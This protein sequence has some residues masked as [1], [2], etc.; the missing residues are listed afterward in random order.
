M[1]RGGGLLRI[2]QILRTVVVDAPENGVGVWLFG[3]WDCDRAKTGLRH[4]IAVAPPCHV[5]YAAAAYCPAT[6]PVLRS[7]AFTYFFFGLTLFCVE[8]VR[9]G[10]RWPMVVLPLSMIFWSNLHG[11]FVIG[12]GVIWFY[13]FAAIYLRKDARR[14]AAVAVV[15]TAVTFINPYGIRFWQYLIPAL[16][17]PRARIAGM[18]PPLTLWAWDD[19]WGFRVFLVLTIAI[20]AAGWKRVSRKNYYGIVI[21]VV[22]ACMTHTR[23]R[24]HAPF[25]GSSCAWLLPGRILPGVASAVRARLNSIRVVGVVYA[26][27]AIFTA[28]QVL[29]RTSL[30]PLAPVG[31]DPVRETD[32]LSRAGV[33]GNLASPFAWGCYL[34]WRLYPDIKISMDGRYEAAYPESTF[35]MKADFFDHQGDWMKS[36]RVPTRW[37][38]LYLTWRTIRCVRKTWRRR[39]TCRFGR[40]A[41]SR[42]A[43]P[44]ICGDFAGERPALFRPILSIRW[45]YS[46][47]L[48]A[49]RSAN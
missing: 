41:T 10:S 31:E 28:A 17:N 38:L 24:R 6:I 43:V 18:A 7:H 27:L 9:A 30:Q 2:D 3:I 25:F 13:A 33:K 44:A 34:S 23:A 4:E 20:M 21:L 16:L 37:I 39:A 40:R 11:G 42:H 32:I 14:F 5:R 49:L 35:L 19:F 48:S 26:G 29:P 36:S 8:S 12:L 15:C 46:L 47:G 1:G 22:T 45:T